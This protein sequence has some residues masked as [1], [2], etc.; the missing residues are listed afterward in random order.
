MSAPIQSPG[1]AKPSSGLV[2]LVLS[3]LGLAGLVMAIAL[4]HRYSLTPLSTDTLRIARFF[5]TGLWILAALLMG[6]RSPAKGLF[7]VELPNAMSLFLF[8]QLVTVGMADLVIFPT[9]AA[10]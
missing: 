1:A 10:Q 3:S 8:V 9:A 2:A 6:M 4:A 7:R 5:A